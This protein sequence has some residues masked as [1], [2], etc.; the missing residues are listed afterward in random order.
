MSS[1]ISKLFVVL[2]IVAFLLAACAPAATEEPAAP[3]APE[4]PSEPAAPEEPADE[5]TVIGFSVYDM[6]YGFF[7]DME[8]GTR[9]ASEEAGYEYILV[10]QKSSEVINGLCHN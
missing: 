5:G 10:D 6:Q 3:A 4:E 2:L 8:A 9:E 1:K 7:Q